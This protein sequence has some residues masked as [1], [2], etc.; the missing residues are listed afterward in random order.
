MHTSLCFAVTGGCRNCTRALCLPRIR[1]WMLS[2]CAKVLNECKQEWQHMRIKQLQLF[3]PTYT[4]KNSWRNVFL[5]FTN[6][7]YNPNSKKVVTRC[8]T[9]T[10]TKYIWF[11]TIFPFFGFK[12]PFFFSFLFF[13]FVPTVRLGRDSARTPVFNY[14]C[15][16]ICKLALDE[17]I[18]CLKKQNAMICKFSKSIFSS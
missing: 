8:T 11:S 1:M 6:G 15:T 12:K 3:G 10:K 13:S 2:S 17:Y 4:D 9:S 7:H 16:S 5:E 14:R 18:Y